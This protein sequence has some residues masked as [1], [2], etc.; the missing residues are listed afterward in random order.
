MYRGTLHG[1]EIESEYAI[2]LWGPAAGKPADLHI[3]SAPMLHRKLDSSRAIGGRQGA[4]AYHV[5]RDGAGFSLEFPGVSQFRVQPAAIEVSPS[6][7]DLG[8]VAA[9][10]EGTVLSAAIVARGD[11]ALHASAV[12]VRGRAWAFV[13]SS[14]AGK[15]TL[16]A[17]LCAG[18][19]DLLADDVLRVTCDG[20]ENI[21]FPGTSRLRL[22]SRARALARLLPNWSALD[23]TDSRLALGPPGAAAKRARLERIAFPRI[24]ESCRA[25]DLIPIRGTEALVRLLRALRIPGW[26]DHEVLKR[27]HSQLGSLARSVPAFELVLPALAF[28]TDS[29]SLLSSLLDRA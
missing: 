17:M 13:G 23:T 19:A 12:S 6:T 11:V 24:T 18:G 15:S 14:G 3:L 21:C 22:R 7:S 8:L 10:L 5:F 29:V 28:D 9:L 27:T 26:T 4:H 1:Y 2:S 16:A 25:P 20:H